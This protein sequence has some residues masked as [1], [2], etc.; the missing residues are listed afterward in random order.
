[1]IEIFLSELFKTSGLT[2]TEVSAKTRISH[3][4]LL[5]YMSGSCFPS[6]NDLEKLALVFNC[7]TDFIL[8][9][10]DDDPN[11]RVI[12]GHEL[13]QKM[14]D[15][16]IYTMTIDKDSKVSEIDFDG[17]LEELSKW[18]YNKSAVRRGA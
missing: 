6:W 11:V 17:I 13:P 14:L 8:G 2:L 10:N 16:G 15:I 3:H 4:L 18:G 9:I 5:N 7:S 1:M 12:R